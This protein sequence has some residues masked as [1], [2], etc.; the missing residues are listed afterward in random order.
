MRQQQGQ[1]RRREVV[2]GFVVAASVTVAAIVVPILAVRAEGSSPDD[3]VPSLP[4]LLALST[5]AITAAL[6]ALYRIALERVRGR[7]APAEGGRS[8]K[9]DVVAPTP[10]ALVPEQPQLIRTDTP[11]AP[12]PAPPPASA[13][14]RLEPPERAHAV[15][16]QV[17]CSI[18]RAPA[19]TPA[20]GPGPARS[21]PAPR[22]VLERG[23][24]RLPRTRA[25]AP[26]GARPSASAHAEPVDGQPVATGVATCEIVWW[27]GARKGGFEARIGDERRPRV[28]GRSRTITWSDATPPTPDGPAAEVHALLVDRLEADGWTLAGAGE[29][30]YALRFE[31]SVP[32]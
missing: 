32:A 4:I 13:E 10:R 12:A 15:R 23:E 7:K 6:L 21:R 28:V 25:A 27:H 22:S 18:S 31:R 5:M 2:A 14:R 20:P 24:G 30:W 16:A 11:P 1:S 3:V 19:D 26:V 8:A 29:G 17:D 9:A